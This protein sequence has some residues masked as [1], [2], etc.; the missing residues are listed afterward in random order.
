MPLGRDVFEYT[1]E[2]DEVVI[3]APIELAWEILTDA[4]H[5]P[6]WNPFTPQIETDFQVGSSVQIEV[7]LGG[8][9][10]S[11]TERIEVLE[12]PTRLAW[13][14]QMTLGPIML[15]NAFREQRLTR[16]D[17]GRCT[18]K[19]WDRMKGPI[20]PLVRLAFDD[21][22]RA[23]FTSVGLGLKRFAEARLAEAEGT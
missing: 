16:L 9:V 7:H 4:A 21:K 15:V 18:Y 8:S 3:D 5:Y 1:A 22:L 19:C 6:E 12:P 10:R 11:E 20:T 14:Q 13:R 17:D 2:S 23:G